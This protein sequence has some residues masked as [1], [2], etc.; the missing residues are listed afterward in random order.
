MCMPN[1]NLRDEGA[2]RLRWWKIIAGVINADSGAVM[3]AADQVPV[4]M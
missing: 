2:T 1:F 3:T 4:R